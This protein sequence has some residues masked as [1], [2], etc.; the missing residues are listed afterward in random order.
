[1]DSRSPSAKVGAAKKL[2][3]GDVFVLRKGALLRSG[4]SDSQFMNNA[5]RACPGELAMMLC[6]NVRA[7]NSHATTP[8]MMIFIPRLCGIFWTFMD[9]FDRDVEVTP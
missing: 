5:L 6:S 1:M 9:N 8:M 4:P 2:C 7:K 3:C